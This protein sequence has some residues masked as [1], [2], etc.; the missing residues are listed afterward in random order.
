LLDRGYLKRH[1]RLVGLLQLGAV[2]QEEVRTSE[3]GRE[4]RS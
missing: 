2:R 1:F 3:P 4:T